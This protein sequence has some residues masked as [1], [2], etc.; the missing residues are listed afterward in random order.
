MLDHCRNVFE[1]RTSDRLKPLPD[2]QFGCLLIDVF[3][4]FMGSIIAAIAWH[5]VVNLDRAKA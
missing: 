2:D 5:A 1:R 3:A 4:I